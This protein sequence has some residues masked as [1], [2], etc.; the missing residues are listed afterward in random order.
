[1][2][3]GPGSIDGGA[4]SQHTRQGSVVVFVYDGAFGKDG[5][6]K[7]ERQHIKVEVDVAMRRQLPAETGGDFST[8]GY[9]RLGDDKRCVDGVVHFAVV[10]VEEIMVA[11]IVHFGI[12]AV[13]LGKESE[14][15]QL[16]E[17]V[18][19]SP[20]IWEQNRG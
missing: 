1:M 5:V 18:A 15:A 3:I 17:F 9:G 4:A 7:R 16:D 12:V 14:V 13:E 10:P 2:E 11:G 20:C 19:D 8:H 6:V